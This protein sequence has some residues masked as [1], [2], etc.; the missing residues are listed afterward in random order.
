MTVTPARS[1]GGRRRGRPPKT[2]VSATS[3]ATTISIDDETDESIPAPSRRGRGRGR[4][5]GRGRGRSR[6]STRQVV[7]DA[8][9]QSDKSEGAESEEDVEQALVPSNPNSTA[10]STVVDN[11]PS[12]SVG[13]ETPLDVEM[14]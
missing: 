11:G 7:D 14:A 6:I 2:S 9:D 10:D 3:L 12:E 5:R 1:R 4:S 8:D 13:A